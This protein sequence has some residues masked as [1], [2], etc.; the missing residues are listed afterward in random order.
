MSKCFRC[1]TDLSPTQHVRRR[2]YTGASV[3]GFN[4]LSNVA[5]NWLLN[6]AI[7]RRPVSIRSN[8]SIR[9][10]CPGCAR[11]LIELTDNA[12]C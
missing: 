1:A 4:L 12:S 7:A 10:V 9:T 11:I 5:L 8:Y 2:V 3:G 6:S